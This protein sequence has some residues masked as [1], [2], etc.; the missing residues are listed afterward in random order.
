MHKK[1]NHSY[2]MRRR[3]DVLHL[4]SCCGDADVTRDDYTATQFHATASPCCGDSVSSCNPAVSKLRCP[5]NKTFP[6]CIQRPTH[7]QPVSRYVV[8]AKTYV[9]PKINPG[10]VSKHDRMPC[11]RKDQRDKS[12]EGIL[13]PWSTF[14]TNITQCCFERANPKAKI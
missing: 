9:S 1:Y 14:H 12:T 4:T 13:W 8:L 11:S 6:L 10:L 7:R 3:R 2:L 5:L